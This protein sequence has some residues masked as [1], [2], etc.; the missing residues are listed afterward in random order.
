MELHTSA[1]YRIPSLLSKLIYK[2]DD[3]RA[4]TQ[5]F[6]SFHLAIQAGTRSCKSSAVRSTE[7]QSRFRGPRSS[8]H[9]A[10]RSCIPDAVLS[11]GQTSGIPT[12]FPMSNVHTRSRSS[13]AVLSEYTGYFQDGGTASSTAGTL[14]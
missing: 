11:Y 12:V 3:T 9:A 10:T 14:H 8:I 5:D 6:T 7:H 4:T 13:N 2:R 1:A